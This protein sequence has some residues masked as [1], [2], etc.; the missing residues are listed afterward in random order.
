MDKNSFQLTLILFAFLF[1]SFNIQAASPGKVEGI[2]TDAETFKIIP[3]ANVE[4]L[5]SVDSVRVKATTTND[6]GKYLIEDIAYG[7]Y[8]LRISCLGYRKEIVSEFEITPEK[9]FI[10]FSITN[11]FAESKSLNEVVI[12]GRKLTGILDDDKTIY[13]VKSKSAEIAQSGLELLRQLPDVTVDYLSD[14]VRMAGSSNILFQVNGRKV[15]KNFLEQLN[16]ELVDK[17][18]VISNPGAKYDSDVDAVIN[19]IVKK[20]IQYGL[21]GRLRA[22]I[23][24]SATILTKNNAS[25]DL[26]LNK[27]RFYVAG[28]YNQYLY[29]TETSNSRFTFLSDTSILSQNSNGTNKGKKMGF[30]YGIDWFSNDNNTL[31]F[32]STIRPKIPEENEITS[33]NN[34]TSNQ[35]NFHNRSKNNLIDKSFY[36]D[37]SLYFLHKFAKKFHEISFESYWSNKNNTRNSDYYEQDYI[38]ESVI[39]NQLKNNVNQFTENSSNQLILKVDHIYP[40]SEKLKISSGYNGTFLWADYFYNNILHSFAD[41]INYKEKRHSAYSNLAWNSGKI[42]IQAGVRYEFSD[43]NIQHGY[44]TTNYYNYFLP[45]LSAQYKLGKKNIFRLSY[46]KSIIRPTVNQLSPTNYNEDSYL[47]SL[48]NPKLKPASIDRIELT[49]R[50]QIIESLYLNYKPYISFVKNDIKLINLTASDT[51]LQRKYTNLGNDFEYGVT[52]SGSLTLFKSWSFSPS[53]TYYR[54]ELK[55][56][57]KY[58]I[59]EDMS[60]TS[61]RLN[62]ASQYELPKGWMLFIEFNYNAPVI[63]YQSTTHR[64]YDF[65]AGFNKAINKKISISAFALNPWSTRYVYDNRTI[66]SNNVVQQTKD[67]IKYDYLF[68]IR[69]GYKFNSGK[70]GKKV[71][72][73][74]ETEEEKGTGK[75]F[76]N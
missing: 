49:H 45:S 33:D 62:I 74:V 22:T 12:T 36:Y 52:F 76:L 37:Y 58:G 17:I 34:F 73:Q 57:P 27:V 8:L 56:L 9:P 11:L 59:N 10:K 39:S 50:I 25:I 41:Q 24:T 32:Y 72:R 3:Y 44:D 21:S 29:N 30:S 15:D 48:G 6:D 1:Q 63:N 46:R 43:V 16:P 51:L 69:L 31:N 14:N 47:Q 26:F 67:A 61:W 70:I 60:R 65:V 5:K 68:L 64:Y 66:I 38:S 19:I 75:G 42:N 35:S 53:W 7:K 28:N 13:Y 2:V 4:L 40:I 18:E 20:N 55:A 71:E 54:R 23:P